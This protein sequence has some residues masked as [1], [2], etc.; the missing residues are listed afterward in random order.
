MKLSTLKSLLDTEPET[1]TARPESL[2]ETKALKALAIKHTVKASG[3]N[4]FESWLDKF[5]ERNPAAH[6]KIVNFN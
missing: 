1:Q 4:D 5:E 6:A 3:D 2:V